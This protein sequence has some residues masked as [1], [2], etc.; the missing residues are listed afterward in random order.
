[1]V[2]FGGRCKAE[3][4]GLAGPQN[5]SISLLFRSSDIIFNRSNYGGAAS[6]Q[7][8]GSSSESVAAFIPKCRLVAFTCKCRVIACG[9]LYGIEDETCRQLRE[10]WRAK[11]RQHYPCICINR[12]YPLPAVPLPRA[13]LLNVRGRIAIH[14]TPGPIYEYCGA[15]SNVGEEQ[16][17]LHLN[18]LRS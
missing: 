5:F 7:Y 14:A 8:R 15:A 2:N 4:E 17:H 6:L 3:P 1:M 9:N 18:G 13:Y 16:P 11:R 10:C 12:H